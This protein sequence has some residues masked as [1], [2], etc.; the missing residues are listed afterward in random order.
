MNNLYELAAQYQ[1]AFL[2]LS[3]MED[4]DPQALSDTLES[5]S[6]D[7]EMKAKN[8]ARYFQNLD[9]EERMIK[10]AEEKMRKRR[11][12]I[13][14]KSERLKDYLKENMLAC[15]ISKISCP[16]FEV[17]LRKTSGR[18]IIDDEALIPDAFTE[19]RESKFIN[20]LAIKVAGDVPGAHIENGWALVIK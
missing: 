6:G 15:A 7:I 18:V 9:A 16:E 2:E 10:E 20:K 11:E 5:L 3:E 17:S 14:N 19:I 13:K 12:A 4:I 1:R 8:I